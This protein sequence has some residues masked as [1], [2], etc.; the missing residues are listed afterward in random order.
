MLIPKNVPAVYSWQL[1]S[2]LIINVL[3]YTRSILLLRDW[4]TF[5]TLISFL[6]FFLFFSYLNNIELK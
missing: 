1:T 4:K 3:E 5:L 6:L 2:I